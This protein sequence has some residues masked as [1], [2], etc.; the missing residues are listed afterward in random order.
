MA[1]SSSL[2]YSKQNPKHSGDGCDI[3]YSRDQ[4]RA[5]FESRRTIELCEARFGAALIQCN[6]VCLPQPAPSGQRRFSPPPQ[7]VPALAQASPVADQDD[8]YTDAGQNRAQ[9][10]VR[11]PASFRQAVPASTGK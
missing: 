3:Q 1:V 9:G 10:V 7:S 8:D 6:M 11:R 4:E 2:L 5:C